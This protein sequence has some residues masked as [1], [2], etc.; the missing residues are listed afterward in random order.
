MYVYVCI[1]TCLCVYVNMVRV[2]SL[3]YVCIYVC[4]YVCVCVCMYVCVH[5]EDAFVFVFC[6]CVCIY[7]C[8]CVCYAKLTVLLESAGLSCWALSRLLVNH[9]FAWFRSSSSC[10]IKYI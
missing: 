8:K 7:V 3:M 9:I 1:C 10:M 2:C 5:M 6:V 4:V